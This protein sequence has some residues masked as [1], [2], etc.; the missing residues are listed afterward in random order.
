MDFPVID[1]WPILSN[2]LHIA[3]AYLLAFPV[4][5]NREKSAQNMGLRTFPLVAVAGCGYVLVAAN[6][7]GGNS[8]AQARILQGLITG[9][10]FIGGGAILKEGANV[11]GTA[12]A[13]SI[14]NTGAIGAAVAYD[15][16][17]IAIVLSL[18]NFITF[19]WLTRL[20]HD[21]NQQKSSDTE[22]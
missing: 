8:E 17:E 11:Y 4:A 16:Y 14:W 22:D 10:G 9:I 1:W 18:V 21:L 5:W 20:K 13:A 6:V 3:A 2:F 12:T 7:L 19:R 15:R